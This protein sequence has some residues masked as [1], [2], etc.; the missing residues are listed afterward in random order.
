MATINQ[1]IILCQLTNNYS[2][3]K[4]GSGKE[5]RKSL[6]G[7]LDSDKHLSGVPVVTAVRQVLP[8]TP[9]WWLG[10]KDSCLYIAWHWIWA[11]CLE[12]PL[13]CWVGEGGK[14]EGGGDWCQ[15]GAVDMD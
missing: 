15:L 4:Q 13:L 6:H 5:K 3:T 11:S 1:P 12:C 14:E 8:H 9:L 10:K 7:T 2:A